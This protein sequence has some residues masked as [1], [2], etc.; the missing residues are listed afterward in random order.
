M[1]EI[2]YIEFSL[3]LNKVAFAVVAYLITNFCE[4]AAAFC[5]ISLEIECNAEIFVT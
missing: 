4:C 1:C 3:N 5:K 2:D